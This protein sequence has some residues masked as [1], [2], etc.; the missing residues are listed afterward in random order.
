MKTIWKYKLDVED[1]QRVEIPHGGKILSLQVKFGTPYIWVLVPNP[2]ETEKDVVLF[3]TFGT[4]HL[5]PDSIDSYT[6][7]GTYQLPPL[8]FHVFYTKSYVR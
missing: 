6:F 4:G 8:V 1:I 7:L 2:E 3:L 5:I